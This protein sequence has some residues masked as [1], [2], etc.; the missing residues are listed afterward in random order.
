MA[1]I[2]PSR[3]SWLCWGPFNLKLALS[4]NVFAFSLLTLPG[5]V[6]QSTGCVVFVLSYSHGLFLLKIYRA[7]VLG[8]SSARTIARAKTDKHQKKELTSVHSLGFFGLWLVGC[9]VHLLEC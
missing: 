3:H 7:A 9:Q 2:A 4:F 8:S 1:A 5:L 6:G